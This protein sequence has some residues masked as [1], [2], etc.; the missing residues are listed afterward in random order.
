MLEII[1]VAQ[2]PTGP[3]EKSKGLHVEA[4]AEARARGSAR[5]YTLCIS[6]GPLG[7]HVPN[8]D[9][10]ILIFICFFLAFGTFRRCE[11]GPKRRSQVVFDLGHTPAKAT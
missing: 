8:W 6:L 4:G 2:W 7:P 11:A 3:K 10:L 5:T 1:G 9:N